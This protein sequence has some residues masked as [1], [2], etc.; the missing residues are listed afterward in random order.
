MSTYVSISTQKSLPGA[1]DYF[2]KLVKSELKTRYKNTHIG[3]FW[4]VLHPMLIASSIV[5]IRIIFLHGYKVETTSLLGF[6]LLLILWLFF[7][8]SA[9]YSVCCLNN[10]SFISNLKLPVFFVP[11]SIVVVSFIATLVNVIVFYFISFFIEKKLFIHF[12]ELIPVLLVSF[13]FVASLCIIFSFLQRFIPDLKLIF[14][15]FVR[16]GLIWLPI[17][18]NLNFIPE[19]IRTYYKNIPFVWVILRTKEIFSNEIYGA[20]TN[21]FNM[22]FLSLL[23]F[24]LIIFVVQKLEQFK[25]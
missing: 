24:A 16:M 15:Y 1:F 3:M 13:F 12:L 10:H 2:I 8:M 21:S 5:I 20:I 23:L 19:N 9:Q 11:L 4:F 14:P 6:Y 25:I 18:Y 22:I 17:F 7:V